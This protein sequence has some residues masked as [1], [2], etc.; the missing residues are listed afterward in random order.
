MRNGE[1]NQGRIQ[2]VEEKERKSWHGPQ[3]RALTKLPMEV[4]KMARK[5]SRLRNGTVEKFDKDTKT[6][7]VRI[8]RWSKKD[9]CVIRQGFG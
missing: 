9:V 1:R 4:G 8:V 2:R 3:E 6:I 5:A 7:V